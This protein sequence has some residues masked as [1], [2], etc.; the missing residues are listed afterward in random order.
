VKC[1]DRFHAAFDDGAS[2]VSDRTDGCGY[3]PPIL[4]IGEEDYLDFSYCLDCGQIQGKFPRD[5]EKMREKQML[6][7]ELRK[8]I[9]RQD[10]E[11]VLAVAREANEKELGLDFTPPTDYW[12][13]W[14]KIDE[15]LKKQI[16]DDYYADFH[17]T[18]VAAAVFR[19]ACLYGADPTTWKD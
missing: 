19:V 1:S 7:N 9:T 15:D 2:I 10:I 5:L 14:H 18:T 12:T 11:R 3:V 4:G 17:A 8:Q 13:A 16:F 6:L